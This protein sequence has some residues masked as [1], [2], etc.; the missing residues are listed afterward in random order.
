MSILPIIFSLRGTIVNE[1]EKREKETVSHA[2]LSF[3]T[4][5]N[6]LDTANFAF[7]ESIVFIIHN[8]WKI[9]MIH[10]GERRENKFIRI[11]TKKLCVVECSS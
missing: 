3:N 7:G 8:R 10:R 5:S 4:K 6:T 1:R 11:H 2:R 9:N